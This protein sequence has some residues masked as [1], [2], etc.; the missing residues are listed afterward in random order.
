MSYGS[1][2]EYPYVDFAELADQ[3][4]DSEEERALEAM[5]QA[6]T[7]AL[8]GV[9]SVMFCCQGEGC[10]MCQCPGC[11]ICTEDY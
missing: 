2:Y 10:H 7:E 11:I 1:D 4:P 3:V 8:P 9:T 6:M 5:R